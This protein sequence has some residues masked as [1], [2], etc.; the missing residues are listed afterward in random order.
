MTH[1]KAEKRYL[2]TVEKHLICSRVNRERLM[3]ITGRAVS[4][5]L[6]DEPDIPYAALVSAIG[7]PKVFAESLLA[8][9]PGGEVERTRKRRRFQF[10]AAIVVLAVIVA[11]ALTF[12]GCFYLKYQEALNGGFIANNETIIICPDDMTTEEFKEYLNQ[13]TGSNWGKDKK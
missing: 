7:E 13:T 3:K 5:C 8:G 10:K 4:A 12:L 2:R 1:D 9:I 6:E 11:T